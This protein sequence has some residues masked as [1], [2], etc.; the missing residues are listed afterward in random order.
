[1]A[2]GERVFEKWLFR[3]GNDIEAWNAV[4]AETAELTSEG[5]TFDVDKQVIFYRKL[6]EGF[7][8][9]V[10][11]I[12]VRYNATGLDEVSLQLIRPDES[13]GIG[14]RFRLY[15]PIKK[16]LTTEYVPLNFYPKD[17][18]GT[19]YIAMSFDGNAKNVSF[20]SVRF[21]HYT[22]LE[23]LVGAWTSFWKLQP[24][25][26]FS[27]NI[28]LG[29]TVTTDRGPYEDFTMWRQ[30][31]ISINAY[32]IVGFALFGIALLF[33]GVWIRR[34]HHVVWDDV[35]RR[36]LRLFFLTLAVVWILYDARM[37][38]EYVRN[39]YNDHAQYVFAAAEDRTFRDVGNFYDFV[40]FVKPL[41]ADRDAYEVFLAEEWPY[42]G[43]LRY[44]TFPHRPN[45]GEPIFDTWVIYNRTDITVA[46]DGRLHF[47]DQPISKPGEVL[48]QFDARSFVFRELSEE[49]S[50]LEQ[51]I[52]MNFSS[53]QS[54]RV[55][56]SG[57]S[58]VRASSTP[59]LRFGSAQH[60]TADSETK[61][62]RL[63]P[64]FS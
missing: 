34:K 19:E 43:I 10:D 23:K 20:D 25:T 39:V 50:E 49:V 62:D 59:P 6:P 5:I 44:E 15:F 35:R 51:Y 60:D 3:T 33:Y 7:H 55:I 36:T 26:P 56:L 4:G 47:N 37:G 42:F 57:E 41:I 48:G 28:I 40:A 16:G 9:H 18:A 30:L 64:F 53:V 14:K 63:D 58:V 54:S 21:L 11:G 32:L 12:S 52:T 27:I 1:M 24:F 8:E 45:P 38:I 61:G 2:A 13:G 22:P 46:D 29:P 31:S 17:I